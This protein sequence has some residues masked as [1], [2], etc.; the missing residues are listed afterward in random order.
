MQA[1]R[2]GWNALRQHFAY[3]EH[4]LDLRDWLAG[5]RMSLAD[6]SAASHIS[7]LDYF[8]DALGASFRPPSSGTARSSRARASGRC[9]RTAGRAFRGL[10]IMTIWTF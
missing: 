1:I 2:A 9:C 6:I 3:L 7:V 4:L 8:G 10:R 5:D